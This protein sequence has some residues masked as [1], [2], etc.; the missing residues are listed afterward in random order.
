MDFFGRLVTIPSANTSKAAV[1]KNVEK[2]YRVTYRYLEGNSA[3]VRR[4][5]KVNTFFWLGKWRGI[6]PQTGV[7]TID[8]IIYLTSSALSIQVHELN[9]IGRS[10]LES[11]RQLNLSELNTPLGL[12]YEERVFVQGSLERRREIFFLP[13]RRRI[14]RWPWH[15]H[16]T[17]HCSRDLLRYLS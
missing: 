10:L 17:L 9:G 4:P 15:E 2:N 5:I 14:R 13:Q 6:A 8:D 16:S 7:V 1:R 11:T 12:P 3:A